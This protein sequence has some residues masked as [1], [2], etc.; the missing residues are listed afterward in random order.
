MG[1][2][3]DV[4]RASSSKSVA[5]LIMD[6]P[7]ALIMKGWMFKQGRAFRTWSSRYFVLSASKLECFTS[8]DST[9]A[10]DEL[11]FLGHRCALRSLPSTSEFVCKHLHIIAEYLLELRVGDRRVVL[12]CLSKSDKKSWMGSIKLAIEVSTTVNHARNLRESL[13][14]AK[15]LHAQG[16]LDRKTNTQLTH[17]KLSTR[18]VHV[19]VLAAQNLVKDGGS[20]DAMCEVTV[21]AETFKTSTVRNQ[22]SPVWKDNNA[23][24]FRVS[25]EDMTI[26]IRVFDK[27]VFRPSTLIAALTIPTASLP[28]MQLEVRM[29]A[30]ALRHIV[31][32]VLT[33]SL[34]YVNLTEPQQRDHELRRLS[35]SLIE[36]SLS[37]DE[38]WQSNLQMQ[39]LSEDHVEE[40]AQERQ[41]SDGRGSPEARREQSGDCR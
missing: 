41:S 4:K 12:A 19:A 20:V 10:R 26:E 28:N 23:A 35:Y 32:A 9:T 24:V 29:Y 11:T 36:P 14:V 21:S 6:G 16:D 13:R 34:E 37:F 22:R 17:T 33:L 5:E 7:V 27:R 38:L 18:M 39:M 40:D 15:A 2:P 25:S 8:G 3:R 31:D 30:L 1:S